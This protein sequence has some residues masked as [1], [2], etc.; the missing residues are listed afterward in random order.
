MDSYGKYIVVTYAFSL[1]LAYPLGWMADKVHAIRMGLGAIAIYAVVMIVGWFGIVGPKS[2]GIIFLIHGVISGCYFTGAAALA[3]ML[4]PK[5]KFAQFASAG[6][7]VFG[8]VNIVFGPAMGIL[9][10]VLGHD[11]RYTFGVGALIALVALVVN[12]MVYRRFMAM[13]G[14]RGYVAP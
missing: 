7:L 11:Y 10:D 5:L 2:Y 1:V 14:P 8:V 9:L 4:F 13:G 12:L 6:G 3:Q